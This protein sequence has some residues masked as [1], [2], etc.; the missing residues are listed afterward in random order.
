[1]YLGELHLAHEAN[2]EVLEDDAV[3]RGE[4]GEDVLDE[5]LLV[6]AELGPVHHVVGEV[7]LLGCTGRG[8]GRGK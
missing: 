7:H 2:A 5:V 3:R 4:E 8:G 1:V 6:L